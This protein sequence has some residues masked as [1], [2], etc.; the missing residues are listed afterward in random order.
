L[1]RPQDT[2]WRGTG[3]FFGALK[4]DGEGVSIRAGRAADDTSIE[5]IA[6]VASGVL[7]G[8][9]VGHWP[10]DAEE[11]LIVVGDDEEERRGLFGHEPPRLS[12][13]LNGKVSQ[14][15]ASRTVLFF[16][17][18]LK[19]RRQWGRDRKPGRVLGLLNHGCI[20]LRIETKGRPAEGQAFVVSI[21]GFL[22]G[23]RRDRYE[24][25]LKA[26]MTLEAPRLTSGSVAHL[27]NDRARG[28]AA[29]AG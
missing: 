29:I 5:L 4:F 19:L 22:H 18:R 2:A 11:P 12:R 8:P 7:P 23:G 15:I 27:K 9:I 24:P 25:A 6:G 16:R 10:F 1:S 21:S 3:E 20:T 13:H 14:Y 28:T 26:R 17:R